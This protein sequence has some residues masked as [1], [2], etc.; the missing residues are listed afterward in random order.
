MLTVLARILA[1]FNT[2]ATAVAGFGLVVTAVGT[3][4]ALITN[5]TWLLSLWGTMRGTGSPLPIAQLIA[6]G[7]GALC[8]CIGIYIGAPWFVRTAAPPKP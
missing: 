8:G 5:P 6:C 7:L 2:H 1:P 4:V 3:F